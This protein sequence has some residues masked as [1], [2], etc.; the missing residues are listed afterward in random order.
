MTKEKVKEIYFLATGIE[1][2]DETAEILLDA[3]KSPWFQKVLKAIESD[4]LEQI[5]KQNEYTEAHA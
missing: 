1:I 4:N 2:A 5:H 3:R